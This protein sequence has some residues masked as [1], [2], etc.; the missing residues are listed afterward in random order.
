V[1]RLV[2][3]ALFVTRVLA[4]DADH[5]FAADDAAGFAQFFDGWTYFHGNE[6][7]VIVLNLSQP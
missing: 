3:L 5:S 6:L 2:A 4:D 7:K 1:L